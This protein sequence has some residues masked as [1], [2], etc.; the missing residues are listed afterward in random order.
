MEATRFNALFLQ[1]GGALILP[2]QVGV[3][4]PGASVSFPPAMLFVDA[5]DT[6]PSDF[7]RENSESFKL[8]L[9]LIVGTGEIDTSFVLSGIVVVDF[10]LALGDSWSEVEGEQGL[11]VLTLE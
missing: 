11:N 4:L 1:I 8:L 7:L 3:N 10:L 2:G 9:W 5:S 6:D